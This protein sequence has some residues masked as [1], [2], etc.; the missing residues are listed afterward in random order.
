MKL[1]PILA[2][3]M[4]SV[5]FADTK[6]FSTDKQF[7]NRKAYEEGEALRVIK[8]KKCADGSDFLALDFSPTES[9]KEKESAVA[10][11]IYLDKENSLIIEHVW[12]EG[13]KVAE[14]SQI[15][16]VMVGPEIIKYAGSPYIVNE[17]CEGHLIR[18]EV[19]DSL[20]KPQVIL[21]FNDNSAT[22]SVVIDIE[23]PLNSKN[24][25]LLESF[26]PCDYSQ[27]GIRNE[28]FNRWLNRDWFP[29]ALHSTG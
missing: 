6:V 21:L 1:L 17:H 5:A 16:D 29:L 20:G 25:D 3:L 26:K 7:F 11:C 12:E 8:P 24:M 14:F 10:T 19:L 15:N 18:S 22:P 4:V 2:A 27:Y 23:N 13:A 28:A 9:S